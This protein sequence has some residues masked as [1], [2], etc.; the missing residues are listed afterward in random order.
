[1][2]VQKTLLNFAAMGTILAVAAAATPASAG[3]HHRGGLLRFEFGEYLPS[4]PAWR[5]GGIS[6]AS[7]A[8]IVDKRGFYAVADLECHGAI[9]TYLGRYN[10]DSYRIFVNSRTGRIEG[11]A[12]A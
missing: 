7:G 11:V 4:E 6:C 12:A 10:G 2:T 1:M 8:R 3:A 5:A 9:F